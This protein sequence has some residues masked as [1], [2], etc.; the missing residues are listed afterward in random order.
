MLVNLIIIIELT[1]HYTL[2]TVRELGGI[3]V[4]FKQK[5]IRNQIEWCIKKFRFDDTGS[6]LRFY[7]LQA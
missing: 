4:S 6:Q 1:Y 5:Y 3:S 7:R 2:I